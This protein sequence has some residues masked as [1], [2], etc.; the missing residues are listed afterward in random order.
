MTTCKQPGCTGTI[1]DDYCDV[2]GSPASTP[3]SVHAG[4]AAAAPPRAPDTGG[5]PAALPR[6]MACA[7]PGCAG[8]IVDDYCDVCGS[9]ASTPAPVP[10]GAAESAASRAPHARS[11]PTAGPQTMACIQPGCTGTIVDEYCD[12][13]GTP[14]SASTPTKPAAAAPTSPTPA[15]PAKPAAGTPTKRAAPSKPAA[16]AQP[17][18]AAQTPSTPAKPAA[19]M[20]AA[21]AALTAA[22]AG[23]RACSQPGCTGTIV[24]DNCDVCGRPASTPDSVPAE[25][26]ASP[27]PAT[28]PGLTAVRR[29]VGVAAVLFLLV[30]AVAF[31]RIAPGSSTSGS[32][33]STAASSSSSP[34][35]T[36]VGT[37]SAPTASRTP[38]AA[39][40]TGSGSAGATIQLENPPDSGNAFQ[41]VR[42]RGTYPGGPDTFLQ[43]QR[44]EAGKWLSFPMLPTK[45]DQSGQFTAYVELGPPG[46][47]R[48]RL[49]DPESGAKSKAFVLVIKG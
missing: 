29:A 23:M 42:I 45:T 18:A 8:T 7:Q 2:C 26:A 43:V 25:A 15:K 48:L 13:C 20:P 38:G 32:P 41:I 40:S 39:G 47:Y 3:A 5:G 33:P 10:A 49:L 11:E 9:P 28:R 14:A 1:V 19:T 12:V 6:T 37:Q 4:A 17:P 27:A 31:Y 22:P 36:S 44:R 46:R 30:C 16:A 21:F 35:P 24:D 34:A